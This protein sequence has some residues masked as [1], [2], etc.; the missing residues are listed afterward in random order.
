MTDLGQYHY[1]FLPVGLLL[2]DRYPS[3]EQIGQ[4]RC[5]LLVIAGDR[6][7]IVP[8]QQSL[9]LFNAA[10]EPKRLVMVPGA[11]HNDY[12]LLAGELLIEEVV[13]FVAAVRLW[14]KS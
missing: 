1:P 2:S 11:D 7:A 4:V 8:P 14:Q 5:P 12:A 10:P 9:R 13:R 3:I 6:D